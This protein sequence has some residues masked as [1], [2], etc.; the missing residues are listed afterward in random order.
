MIWITIV[1]ASHFQFINKTHPKKEFRNESSR[2]LDGGTAGDS[3][4]KV[5]G[6]SIRFFGFILYAPKFQNFIGFQRRILPNL[7]YLCDFW[8]SDAFSV[9]PHKNA[10]ANPSELNKHR[11]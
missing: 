7:Y 5:A 2:G 10:P 9:R 4:L 6:E 3:L 11:Q 8:I 1:N